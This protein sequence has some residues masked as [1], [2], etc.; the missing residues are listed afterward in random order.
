[1]ETI[2]SQHSHKNQSG[3]FQF[4]SFFL[5]SFRHWWGF[6]P[7]LG[8]RQHFCLCAGSLWARLH[9][10]RGSEAPHVHER[11]RRPHSRAGTWPVVTYQSWF[12]RLCAPR[13][14]N[15]TGHGSGCGYKQ[16]LAFWSELWGLSGWVSKS[17]PWPLSVSHWES[18][19]S[20][21]GTS[22]CQR[23]SE[24][25]SYCFKMGLRH[26]VRHF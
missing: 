15:V 6:S 23:R 16:L 11:G 13:S 7:L 20:T 14:N 26:V 8:G 22:A 18:R 3:L 2:L 4:L 12:L 5:A 10:S 1:M 19:W 24:S 21:C 17:S 25:S 9:I